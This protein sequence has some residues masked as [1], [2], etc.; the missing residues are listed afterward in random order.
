MHFSDFWNA[1]RK[2]LI[3]MQLTIPRPFRLPLQ[4][5]IS[6]LRSTMAIS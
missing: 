3:C 5:S 1:D 2:A 4:Y 6:A